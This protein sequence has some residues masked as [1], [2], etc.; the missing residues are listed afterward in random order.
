MPTPCVWNEARLPRTL[1]EWR[2]QKA[3]VEDALS[4]IGGILDKAFAM[5]DLAY[6]RAD[7][8]RAETEIR[9]WAACDAEARDRLEVLDAMAVQFGA[10]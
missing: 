6:T 1:E 9:K 7:V 3:I 5:M 4:V 2:V 10:A 8:D